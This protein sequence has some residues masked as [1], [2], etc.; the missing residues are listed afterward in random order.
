M[1]FFYLFSII[2]LLIWIINFVRGVY[3]LNKNTHLKPENNVLHSPKISIIIPARNEALRLPIL[4]NSII[5]QDY[6]PLE[7]IVVNDN[8]ED[9]TLEIAE[10]Y[11]GKIP[12]LKI[13]SP[14]IEE[15]WCGKN[16]ALTMGYRAISKESEWILFID[17][18]CELKDNAI[19]TIAN[20][21]LRNNLDCLSLF[22]DVKSDKFFERLLL[23]S[24]GAMVTLFNSPGRVNNP[25][26]ETSFINGQFVFIKPSVYGDIGTHEAVKDAI[27]EDAALAK[28]L[29]SKGYRI[30]LGFGEDIF[31]V[32]MYNSFYDF[33]NGW[34]KN[35]FLILKSSISNLFKMVF[36]VIILSFLP[37]IWLI[38]GI[39]NKSPFFIGGYILVLFFQIYLRYRSKT[40]PI[41]AILAPISSTIVSFIA[42]RSA[43][44]HIMKKGVDWKG[45][46]YFSSR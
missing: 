20:F 29:K 1:I 30:F 45:R 13:V 26:D 37:V 42:I 3:E 17:A 35:M 24:V 14:S 31:I 39:I 5:K 11:R 19:I 38:F 43:Y 9:N 28:N 7:V 12:E 22:P 25:E 34:T 46:R 18:D 15:G 21:A 8:S 16:F 32:R 36:I 23:P 27:L 10:S 40:Y 6:K 41:Y 44:R 4:L 33:I 2:V